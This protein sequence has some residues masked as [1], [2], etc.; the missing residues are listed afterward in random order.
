MYAGM[1]FSSPLNW[2]V[3]NRPAGVDVLAIPP[4]AWLAALLLV[5]CGQALNIGIFNAIGSSGV[6]YG[7]KLGH[8]IPWVE[9]LMA[10]ARQ[11]GGTG[12]PR[13]GQPHK[14][15]LDSVHILKQT[16]RCLA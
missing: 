8:D 3:L 5:G 15:V 16:G 2:Y 4:L 14:A 11:K 13:R 10:D 12:T 7:S 6:Y 1:Q 9:G